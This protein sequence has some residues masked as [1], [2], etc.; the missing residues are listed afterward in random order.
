MGT[1]IKTLGVSISEREARVI[2]FLLRE[3]DQRGTDIARACHISSE[4]LY[5]LLKRM[6]AKQILTSRYQD[7][8][9]YNLTEFGKNIGEKIS[10]IL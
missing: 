8:R 3:T 2:A 10:S 4:G 1:L 5:V 6:E 9:S 7:F